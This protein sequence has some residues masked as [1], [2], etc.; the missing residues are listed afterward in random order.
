MPSQEPKAK[1]KLPIAKLILAAILLGALAVF[2]LRGVDLPALGGRAMAFIRGLGPWA[3]FTAAAV[4]PA[5]GAPLSAFTITAGELFAPLLTLPGAIAATLLAV[6]GNL[7]LTYWLAR[8]ALRPVLSKLADRYG[9][10]VPRVT[11]A[12]ALSVTLVL[13]LTPGIPFFVQSYILGLAEV[14]FVFYM[15]VSW[16]CNLPMAIGAVVLG[17]GAFN[18]NFKMVG[19]GAFVLIV[20]IIIIHWLRRKYVPRVN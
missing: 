14:P 1:R 9:Y 7:A 17:K 18:G 19:V 2:F 6:L 4:L 10:K 11:K 20:A 3:F 13:R 12:N 8:Y 15:V 5:F 16:T